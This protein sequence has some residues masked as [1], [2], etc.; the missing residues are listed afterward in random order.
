MDATGNIHVVWDAGN[1]GCSSNIDYARSTDGGQTFSTPL[2]LSNAPCQDSAGG[3]DLA[4]DAAG[5]L[6][7]VWDQ[8]VEGQ[9]QIYFTRSTGG[10]LSFSEPSNISHA[11][12]PDVGAIIPAVASGAPGHVYVTWMEWRNDEQLFQTVF[13]FS[14][15][16]GHTFS[17]PVQLSFRG[18]ELEW[19]SF[20]DVA[21]DSASGRVYVGWKHIVVD[22][23]V[24]LFL[25][26]S[27]DGGDT[28][29]DPVL[30]THA[31]SLTGLAG[32]EVDGAGTLYAVWI[33]AGR[34]YLKRSRDGGVTFSKRRRVT[35]RRWDGISFVWDVTVNGPGRLYLLWTH[36][37]V[38][39]V[40]ILLR[41]S[42]NSARRFKGDFEVGG[43]VDGLPPGV[44]V[45]GAGN[46][47]VVFVAALDPSQIGSQVGIYFTRSLEPLP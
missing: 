21:V 31:G 41:F 44:A 45:D 25:R 34:N 6:Y 28:F 23:S 8:I 32:L 33:D 36:G 10:G 35:P 27:W 43:P 22:S 39:E 17:E 19:S 3:A 5:T 37:P 18:G 42:T 40:P 7:V 12:F 9:H 4:V 46:V 16:G 38:F 26:R 2:N 20:P 11:M 24:K 1:P 47:Y 15:D 14:T 13:S 30:L 29:A